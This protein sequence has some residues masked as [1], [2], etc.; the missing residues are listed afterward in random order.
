MQPSFSWHQNKRSLVWVYYMRT[1]QGEPPCVS[2]QLKVSKAFPTLQSHGSGCLT[3]SNAGNSLVSL[4]LSTARPYSAPWTAA[5]STVAAWM[6]SQESLNATLAHLLGGCRSFLS[7]TPICSGS[8]ASLSSSQRRLLSV[9][10]MR[11]AERHCSSAPCRTN[12]VGDS[13]GF[14]AVKLWC[15]DSD[16]LRP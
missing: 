11:L 10:R 4:P 8:G 15:W 5:F 2:R 1:C 9:D 12:P 13:V 7:T 3:R 16:R 6:R 14:P